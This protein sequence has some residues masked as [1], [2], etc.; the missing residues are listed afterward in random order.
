METLWHKLGDTAEYQQEDDL[1][2]CAKTLT[3]LGVNGE[4]DVRKVCCG[5]TAIGFEAENYISLF[6]GDKNAQ[7]DVQPMMIRN[8]SNHEFGALL[9]HL[10]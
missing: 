4:S 1:E 8:L 3:T 6:W 5:L 9:S 2:S 10:T 7:G